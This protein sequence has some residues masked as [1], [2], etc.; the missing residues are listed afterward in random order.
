MNPDDLLN[1]KEFLETIIRI[2]LKKLNIHKEKYQL[3]LYKESYGGDQDHDSARKN[4][5]SFEYF[6]EMN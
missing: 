2:A 4:E 6:K 3:S 1:R 5:V